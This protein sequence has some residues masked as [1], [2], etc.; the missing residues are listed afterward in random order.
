MNIYFYP[1]ENDS[2]KKIVNN[3]YSSNFIDSLSN[4]F[5]V[6]KKRFF[7]SDILDLSIASFCYKIVILNWVEN[8][9]FKKFSFIQFVLLRMIFFVL[10][11]RKVKV[12]WV[13]HNIH[14][15]K[16][17][18]FMSRSIMGWLYKNSDL[19][20]THSEQAKIYLKDK[21]TCDVFYFQHPVIRFNLDKHKVLDYEKSFSGVDIFI[22]GTIEPYK[23]ILEFIEF[24]NNNLSDKKILIIGRCLNEDYL[25]NINDKIPSNIDFQ[26]RK[27]DFEEVAA[28]S[29]LSKCV[30]FPYTSSSI[31][32][33]GV[34]MDT[35][36]LG[37]KIVGP[38]IGAFVD[39]KKEKLCRTYN[40]LSELQSICSNVDD[41]NDEHVNLFLEN[42]SWS[43]F[44]YE[45]S[46][47]ISSLN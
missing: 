46:R 16:G 7:S 40:D 38:N 39:L 4:F 5:N 21:A 13:M 44:A 3:P 15:H 17:H 42:N 20:V 9:A 24:C 36:M 47:K 11:I 37:G 22:W 28:I 27:I 34:L 8:V 18:N 45:L 23:G 19:I 26:N 30:L 35:L 33:S 32:S 29:K 6:N 31:S 25:K 41:N 2:E 1:P 10:K 43:R 14:P 12:V